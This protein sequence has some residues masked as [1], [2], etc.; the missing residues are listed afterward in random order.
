[1]LNVPLTLSN[2]NLASVMPSNMT[3]DPII[4]SLCAAID[5]INQF[6]TNAIPSV[7]VLANIGNQPSAVTD[8][9][10]FEQQ[11]PYYNQTLPLSTRQMLLAN[12]GMVNSIKGTKAAVEQTVQAAFGSGTVQEWFEYGGTPGC[13]RVL[14]NDFPNS[15]AQMS[16]I[17]RAIVASQRVSSH[18]D[19]VIIILETTIVSMYMA[20]TFELAVY[21]ST[22]MKPYVLPCQ[23]AIPG[24]YLPL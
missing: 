9:L 15:S 7:L 17:N 19:E 24:I 21:V 22:A 20:S 13:F 2:I 10:A 5:A 1:M 11:T 18:L 4:F 23:L 3:S 16:E 14:V 8:L 6:V 12:T